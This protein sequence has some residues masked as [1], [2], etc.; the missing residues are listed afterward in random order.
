[1]L[2]IKV[3]GGRSGAPF[4]PKTEDPSGGLNVFEL[5][6]DKFADS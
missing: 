1:M 6:R 3:Q 5:Y 2:A 4:D